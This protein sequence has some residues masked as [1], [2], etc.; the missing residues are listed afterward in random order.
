VSDHHA[1]RSVQAIVEDQVRRWQLVR[2]DRSPPRELPARPNV[3][4]ISNAFGS[5]AAVLARGVGERLDIPVYDREIVAH[6]ARTAHV[7]EQT[8]EAL[9]ERVLRRVDNFV[10]ALLRESGFDQDDYLRALLQTIGALWEHGP[11]V[12]VGHGAVHIVP[13][14]H[15]L[16]VRVV[17]TE[18][19]RVRRVMILHRLTE[20]EARE[21]VRRTDHDRETFHR[22]DFKAVV[23]NP[24]NYDLVLNTSRLPLEVASELMIHAYRL[25][26]G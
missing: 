17:A 3:V 8:V 24:T 22:R 26:F 1:T 10:L 14:S 15:A 11:C 13:R 5:G 23:E 18:E 16:A 12:L 21:L 20:P 19:D 4:A 7:R 2:R 9:D 25:K 6:I